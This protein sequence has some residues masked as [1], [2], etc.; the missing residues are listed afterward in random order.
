MLS[1]PASERRLHVVVDQHEVAP[2]ELAPFICRRGRPKGALS[3]LTHGHIGADEFALLRAVVQGVDAVVAYRHYLLFPGR[4][5]SRETIKE[6]LDE[7]VR[8]TLSAAALIA[9]SSSGPRLAALRQLLCLSADAQL[10]KASE[11]A[12]PASDTTRPHIQTLEE[13][14]AQYPEG[15]YSEAELI[16]L[17]RETAE[18]EDSADE[19]GGGQPNA[20]AKTETL[21]STVVSDSAGS[22]APGR[23]SR[24]EM[25]RIVEA[26]DWLSSRVGVKPERDQPY[27][28][29][30]RLGPAQVQSLEAVGVLSLGNLVDWITLRGRSWHKEVSR[31]GVTRARRLEQWLGQW[32]IGPAPG[33]PAVGPTTV[34]MSQ[35]PDPLGLVPMSDMVWPANLKGERGMFRSNSPNSLKASN[36]LEA[37]Q[38]WFGLLQANSVATQ[39]AYRRAIERLVL[40]A[41][42]EKGLELSSL[43]TIDL[44]EFKDFLRSPPAHWVQQ[45]RVPLTKDAPAWRPLRGPLN[46][47]S[48]KLTFAAISAMFG[49]WQASNYVTGNPATGVVRSQ[50]SEVTLD[51]MRSFSSQDEATIAETFNALDDGPLK[52][53]LLALMRLLQTA[54]LRRQ[55]AESACWD[56]VTPVRLGTSLS[57]AWALKVLGK[58]KRERL[59]PL[60]DATISALRDHLEDRLEL[61]KAGELTLFTGVDP[62][63]APLIGVLDE[64]WIRAKV[65]FSDVNPTSPHQ[66]DRG[67][68]P[69]GGLTAAGMY[70]VLKGFFKKCATRAGQENS[71]FARASGH[72]LRHTFAHHALQASKN[73]LPVV[74]QLLG[75]ASITTTAI[76]TKADMAL[77]VEV[78]K[79]VKPTI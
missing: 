35:E 79:L 60:N 54:G 25:E 57:D 13:F 20:P 53:R 73:D 52:R 39:T 69:N 11:A 21:L 26:L 29:W 62:S 49:T 71:D 55:E 27:K 74:Q 32:E 18:L 56:A 19:P 63:R 16:E 31:F 2:P 42:F 40:W 72:W 12:S 14:A 7:L 46:D 15:M 17:Y 51:V 38:A 77:R 9:D 66:V 41:L 1:V 76:Y 37:V 78:V 43:A 59:V 75:H 67:M 3:Q 33:L 23:Y 61:A 5:P 47:K 70:A 28:Q 64:R 10:E 4:P 24:D 50:R 34:L 48:L 22:P 45:Q 58:G 68:N 30:L 65:K 6:L 8:R 44:I 36:D